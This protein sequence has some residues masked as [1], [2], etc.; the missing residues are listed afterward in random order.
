MPKLVGI[1]ELQLNSF[2]IRE[3]EVFKGNKMSSK[4]LRALFDIIIQLCT[5]ELIYANNKTD[6]RLLLLLP[7]N[8]RNWELAISLL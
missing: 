6:A 4:G 5:E 2:E 7:R 8:V 1:T 3:K